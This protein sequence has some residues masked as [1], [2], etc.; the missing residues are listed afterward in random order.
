MDKIQHKKL[1]NDFSEDN[2][3]NVIENLQKYDE[4][5]I[6]IKNRKY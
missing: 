6:L 4:R 3:V 1:I 5:I 2:T